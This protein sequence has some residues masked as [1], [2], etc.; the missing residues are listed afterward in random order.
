LLTGHTGFKGSWFTCWLQ[1]LGATVMGI[2]LPEAPTKPSLYEQLALADVVDVRADITTSEWMSRAADFAPEVV[3][4]LAAQSLVAVGLEL[5]FRTFEVNVLGTARLMSFLDSLKSLRSAIL[6]TTDKV[7][8]PSSVG[9][10]VETDSLGG[11]DPYAASK[12]AAEMVVAGWPAFDAPCATARAGNVIGGGDW[13]G[14]RLLPDLMRAWLKGAPVELRHPEAVRPWQHVVE[15]LCG[16]LLYAEA[17]ASGRVLPSAMNF[18][19]AAGQSVQVSE[20]VDFAAEYWTKIGRK[21]PAQPVELVPSVT[22]PETPELM[23]DAR[24]ATATLGWAQA[25]D[26][27]RAVEATIDWYVEQDEGS[28]PHDL[29]GRQLDEYLATARGAV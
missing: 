2:S 29:V 23:L 16:Y 10:H 8:A 22:F 17:L 21:L 25:F 5:P 26:W 18:G 27:R 3:F 28:D 7:Y 24:L 4:H 1:A 11:S 9:A 20:V 19:P 15:P 12:A 6:V 13:A 14:N